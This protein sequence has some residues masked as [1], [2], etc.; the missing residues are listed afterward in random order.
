MTP[1]INIDLQSTSGDKKVRPYPWTCP[2]CLQKKVNLTVIPYRAQRR[3][4][5]EMTSVEIAA[6]RV[7]KCG[8]CGE[9]VITYD[10]DDQIRR[11]LDDAET[12]RIESRSPATVTVTSAEVH[13][14]AKS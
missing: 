7:P 6:L 8:H 11:A 2:R 4:G 3:R 1:E 5:G 9:L 10:V 12:Q 14:S 13:P